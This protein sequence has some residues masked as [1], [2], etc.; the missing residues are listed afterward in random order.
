MKK[1]QDQTNPERSLEEFIATKPFRRLVSVE[2][3]ATYLGFSPRTIYNRIGPKAKDPF[4]VRPVR[5]GKSVKFDLR[6]LDEFIE[7]SKEKF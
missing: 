6:D 3:T 1:G 2:D 5:I 7:T 4:P